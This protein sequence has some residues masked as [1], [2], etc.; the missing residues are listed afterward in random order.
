MVIEDLQDVPSAW[1]L[2]LHTKPYTLLQEMTDSRQQQL[3]HNNC[4]N[5]HKNMIHCVPGEILSLLSSVKPN[6]V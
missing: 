2:H 5:V 6:S 3:P 1:P 4:Q